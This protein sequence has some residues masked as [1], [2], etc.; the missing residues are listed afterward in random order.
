MLNCEEEKNLMSAIN[1]SWIYI[2]T[3]QSILL[4]GLENGGFLPMVN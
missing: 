1:G 4:K 2:Y 3:I